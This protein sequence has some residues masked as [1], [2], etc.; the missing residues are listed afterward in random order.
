MPSINCYFK[1]V[2]LP[3]YGHDEVLSWPYQ[4]SSSSLVFSLALG[5]GVSHD[6]M[7]FFIEVWI[8]VESDINIITHTIGVGSNL[9]VVRPQSGMGVG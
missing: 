9:M 4:H 6:H 3:S 1:P 2:L 8:Y 7:W 5:A